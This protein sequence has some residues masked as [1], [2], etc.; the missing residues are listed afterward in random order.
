MISCEVVLN[1]SPGKRRTDVGFAKNSFV[2]LGGIEVSEYLADSR[3]IIKSRRLF[4]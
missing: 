2:P 1:R 3:H 4:A